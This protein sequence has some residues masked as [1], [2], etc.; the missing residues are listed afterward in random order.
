ME[1]DFPVSWLNPVTHGQ[2]GG[3]RVIMWRDIAAVSVSA[4][5]KQK[6]RLCSEISAGE[7]EIEIDSLAPSACAF[8]RVSECD[9]ITAGDRGQSGRP[10]M[11]VLC[12]RE[13]WS[14]CGFT[15]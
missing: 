11:S 3:I 9:E 5:E 2:D 10:C 15:K 7:W 14:L 13:E 4:E 1:L 8:V 6:A 12:R